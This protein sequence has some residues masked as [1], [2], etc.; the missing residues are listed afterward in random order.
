MGTFKDYIRNTQNANSI[1]Q[2][3]YE[4]AN[5]LLEGA[6]PTDKKNML[7]LVSRTV[8]LSNVGSDILLELSQQEIDCLI[9]FFDAGMRDDIIQHV[10]ENLYAK[11]VANLELTKAKSGTERIAQGTIGVNF[12]SQYPQ[13][14]GFGQDL[15]QYQIQD[16]RSPQDPLSQFMSKFKG[17]GGRK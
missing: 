3:V 2:N 6:T 8:K 11:F 16:Q 9:D 12:Q 5:S 14:G 1:P 10:F 17:V 15:P 4:H 13:S 7:N